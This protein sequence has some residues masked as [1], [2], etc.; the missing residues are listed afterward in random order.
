M[1]DSREV[2]LNPGEWFFG[3]GSI[4]LRTVLGS[5][6]ALVFWHPRHLL[7]GMCHYLLPQRAVAKPGVLDGRYGNEALELLLARIHASKVRP[8]EFRINVY[9]GG[10]MFPGLARADN[11]YVGQRNVEQARRLLDLHQ[12]PCHNFH[13]EGVGYRTVVLDLATGN[14]ELN[15]LALQRP[16]GRPHGER[17][18]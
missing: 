17:T 8:A 13:V 1:P 18:T 15:Y 6:V 16:P 3:A 14:I 5:C 9:G 2:F 7:G 10:D 11:H 4:R 12:L